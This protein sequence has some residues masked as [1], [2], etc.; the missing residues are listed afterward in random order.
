MVSSWVSSGSSKFNDDA[1]SHETSREKRWFP[2][3]S[4]EPGELDSDGFQLI[5]PT[6]PEHRTFS[7]DVQN[8][9]HK[10]QCSYAFTASGTLGISAL[11]P[12]HFHDNNAHSDCALHNLQG[13]T[14]LLLVVSQFTPFRLVLSRNGVWSGIH[15][16]IN[17]EHLEVSAKSGIPGSSI[18]G[19][20]RRSRLSMLSP[21]SSCL[22]VAAIFWEER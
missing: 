10:R 15:S 16:P 4:T 19:G 13:P 17:S 6:S 2:A 1:I 14:N 9:M 11:L 18:A 20:A 5:F 8:L 22:S 21:G 7:G 3:F 12:G